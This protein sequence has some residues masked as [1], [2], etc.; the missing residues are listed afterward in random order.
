M[1]STIVEVGPVTVRGPGPDSDLAAIAVAGIDDE[2]TLVDD[3]P[4]AVADLWVQV[5]D[6]AAAG[7]RRLT[8]VCPTWWTAV[9]RD[10]VRAAAA[11][12]GAEVVVMQRVQA[13][14]A[15]LT[16]EL[17]IVV[18]IADE[19]VVVSA[20]AAAGVTLARHAEDDPD[21]EAV[22][23]AVIAIAGASAEVAVDAPAEVAGAA[24]LGSAVL[25]GLRRR[26][27]N[28]GL[29]DARTWREALVGPGTPAAPDPAGR[30]GRAGRLVVGGATIL[31]AVLGA[32]AFTATG[33]PGDD[34]AMTVLVE[35]RVGMQ[36]PA[37]WSV[38]RVTDGP[39]SARVE[40]V[41]PSDPQVRIHVTQSGVGDGPVAD[42]L[43]RALEEQPAG[44]FVDFDPAAV[45]AARPV[46]SY[47]EVRP[48]R[49]IRWAVF[50]DRA[51]RIAIGCQS[52]P[53]HAAAVRSACEAATRSAHATS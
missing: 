38:Q 10:R 30:R 6:A 46:V 16:S 39:G 51:V 32:I 40:V 11:S 52:A 21:P 37:G 53:G 23:R 44:V 15:T 41:S 26:G 36:I 42:T 9:Q 12:C 50:V 29:A 22:V 2:I 13:V 4:V 5:L 33:G 8:L 48:G 35:G 17:W 18:E 1:T 45:I 31:A 47:R 34:G 14:S 3:E 7:A 49:E 28:V 20:A 43:R 19:V 25:A 27:V 24:A